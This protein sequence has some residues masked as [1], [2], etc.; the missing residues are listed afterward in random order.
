MKKTALLLQT[1][2]QITNSKERVEVRKLTTYL[3]APKRLVFFTICF[4]LILGFV[5]EYMNTNNVY[6]STGINRTINFQGKVVNKDGT[7]VADGQYTFVFKLY[8]A[9]SG[10]SNPWTETQNNVQVTAGIF[11]VSLG[12]VTSFASAGVDFNTDNLYLGINFNSD[13]EMTPRIR[14][15]AVPY[16]INAETVGGLI[17]TNTTGTLTV[18]NSK[19]VQFGG[20]FTTSAQDLTLTLAG[21]TNVTL[22]TTGTLATLAGVENLSNKS[23]TS[24]VTFS[25]VTADI[26]TGTNESLN[27]SPNG[28]GNTLV[29]SQSGGQAALIV[30]KTGLGDIFAASASGVPRFVINTD[31]TASS[32]AGFTVDGV[33]NIQSTRNQTLTIGGGSTGNLVLGK[34]GQVVTIPG[35]DCSGSGNGGKLTTTSGGVL[36]CATDGSGLPSP[37]IESTTYGTIIQGN[38]TEDLLIGGTASSSAEFAVLGIADGI[39]PSA[40]VSATAGANATKGIYME[41]DGSLQAVRNNT[42]T[43]GGD[44]TGAIVFKPGNSSTSL[45]LASNGAV[46][47][48][49]SFGSSGQCLITSGVGSAPIWGGCVSGASGSWFTLQSAQGTLFPINTTLDMLWGGIATSSARFHLYGDADSNKTPVASISANTSAAGLVIDNKG[50]GDLITA[51]SSGAT[52]FTVFQNG[53]VT[54]GNSG[55]NGYKLEVQGS[56]KIGNNTNGDDINKQTTADFTQSGYSVTTSD[57]VN[58]IDTSNNQISLVT[59]LIGAGGTT[60]APAAGPGV[61]QTVGTASLT[62]QRPDGKFVLVN[63]NHVRLY[64]PTLNRFGGGAQ[65][66][67]GTA[68]NGLTAFQRANGTFIVVVGGGTGT[69]IYAP[70]TSTNEQGTFVVGPATTA[71]VGVG[72]VVIRRTDG[73]VLL[74]HGG[75]VGTTSVYDPTNATGTSSI[76]SFAIGPAIASGGTVTT[77]SFQFGLPNGKWIVGLGGSTTTNVYDPTIGNNP[78]GGGAFTAGPAL[79]AASGAGAHVIQLPDNR[80]LV[81]LGGTTGATSIYNPATNTFTAGPSLAS[82]GTVGAGGHSFQR[83]DGKWVLVRGGASTS[84]QL[85]DPSSGADGS[86]STLASGLTG[87]GAGSGAHTFQRPDGMYVVVNANSQSTTTL[88]DA[89]WNTSGTWTSED[90]TSTKISTYSAMIWSANPQSANNNARFDKE[91]LTFSIKTAASQAGLTNANWVTLHDNGLLIKAVANAQWAKIKVEFSTPV[92]SYQQIAS[93]TI[94]QRNIWA[95]EGEVYY[96]RSLIQPAVFSI[97]VQNPLVSYGDLTGGGDPAFGRNF[98]TDSAQFEGVVTDN[99]NRLLLATNRNLPTAT[100]S[101]GLIIASASANLGATAGA[102]THTI[103][104]SNGQFLVIIGGT[105][106]TRIYDSATGVFSNGPALP[107]PAGAG[108]HSFLLPDGRFFTVL[109]GTTNKTAIFDT[110][111]NV[112]IAG[113]DLYGNV[114][115]GANTFIR[116]DGFYV[117]VN[118]GVTTNT[119]ILDPYSMAITQGPFTLSPIGAGALNIRRP[120]GRVFVMHG[121]GV[122]TTPWSS[123]YDAALN[124]FTAG[125]VLTTG[126]LNNGSTAVQLASGRIWIK[127][128]TTLSQVYDPVYGTFAVGPTA[129]GTITAGAV[130]IPRPDGKFVYIAG[131][132]PTIIDGASI[133]AGVT[134]DTIPCT[135]A[136]GSNVFQKPTGEFVV[137]CGNSANTFV[138]DAGWNLG[139]TYTS[140]P[141]YEPNLSAQTGMYWKN[142]GQGEVNVKYR[143]ASTSQALGLA[144][145]KQL[146][147]N[148]SLLS[149]SQGDVWFQTRI[150]LQGVLQDLPGAK[151]RVWLSESNGGAVKYFQQV[152]API[153]QYWKL[154]NASDPNL[155]T[156]TS[157]G[158]NIF[159]FNADGQAFTSDNG[160]WNSGGADLAERYTSKDSLEAGDVVSLDRLNPQN[161]KRSTLSYDQNAMGV[162]STQPGFVAG[163]YTENSYPIALVGRVPVKV[164][165]ENGEIHAGDYLTSASIPGYAMKATVGGRVLG[166]AMEDFIADFTNECPKYNAGNLP[167]TKCGTITVFVNLTSYNGQSVNVAM[168]DSGFTLNEKELPVI[169]GID[170]SEGTSARRQQEILGFLKT[171]KDNGQEIYTNRIAAT[172]EIISPQIVTDLLIAKKIKAE[173]IEGLEII[174]NSIETLS[175][176]ISTGSAVTNFSDRLTLLAQNQDQF[177]SQMASIAAKLEM[178]DNLNLLTMANISSGEGQLTTVANLAVFNTATFAQASVLDNLQVGNNMTL[179]MNAINTI[180]ADLEIQ[181]LKQGAVS[182]LGGLIRFDTDGKATFAEDVTFQKN[183]SVTGVLSAH[184]VASTELQL[185]QGITTVLSDTEV[186]STAAAGLVTLKRGTDHMKVNNSLVKESSFIFIT[187]KSKTNQNLFLL[188]QKEAKDDENGSFTVGVDAKATDDIKFNY[189]IVN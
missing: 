36:T 76:G 28:I 84:L 8:D 54:I 125:P 49:G 121:N 134:G 158:S 20:A 77:G 166:Q 135:L 153:L 74:I 14:F 141:L 42:L 80:M 118:G 21:A 183:V 79:S 114:G 179:S 104:R 83:S 123:M 150:D 1:K 112:F 35:F 58:D 101:A 7:N 57:S 93:G 171:Q 71:A 172:Q 25:G 186:D 187:T 60:A 26:T 18:P 15:A 40:S 178:M 85:Y 86:F 16:A 182:F 128:L 24:T 120:D 151:T 48:N 62:F 133:V 2:S 115:L 61:G 22:P 106:T 103:E 50:T 52:R 46:G 139:G 97:K 33:G 51:S 164:S 152:Q 43:I 110:Q 140:E 64:D 32:S 89:G 94:F 27:I 92:R 155:L 142:A 87:T 47:F 176:R 59:D 98:A 145:W 184:T 157:N 31:G 9:S 189:L 100:R 37:F 99:S 10:G 81:I 34:T 129:N 105:S 126:G 66:T 68:G 102:G 130:S 12:S 11:R 95:G 78:G 69:Q 108:G 147:S 154:M 127:T 29:Q 39:S 5:F 136:A 174:T 75:G 162:V 144:S 116:P 41:G 6:A 65:F 44:T 4:V 13:G 169:S 148:G 107:S 131:N 132:V 167:A 23:F 56:V 73:K 163:A 19:T 181:P 3:T 90:I 70:G 156:I 146:P 170:F 168:E 177:Q 55:D 159:R 88:Y 72:S 188:D 185:A 109:G 67:T 180:G 149:I 53:N 124:T 138:L 38:T 137:I 161:T 175:N 111:S 165:N 117:I 119:N 113:P 45:T 143:T 96:R 82:A 63:G 173:S 91:T 160:A 17:V 122:T 30:D